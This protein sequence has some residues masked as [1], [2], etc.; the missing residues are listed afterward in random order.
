MKHLFK[1]SDVRDYIH[2]LMGNNLVVEFPFEIEVV[3]SSSGGTNKVNVK[4]AKKN[5]LNSRPRLYETMTSR[6]IELSYCEVDK[7]VKEFTRII[8][9]KEEE[10][11]KSRR[12]ELLSKLSP[13]VGRDLIKELKEE[14]YAAEITESKEMQCVVELT[15]ATIE[16]ISEV[17]LEHL[18]AIKSAATNAA[19]LIE[20]AKRFHNKQAKDL[21]SVEERKD[22]YHY[23]LRQFGWK[24]DIKKSRALS[25]MRDLYA[26][27]LEKKVEIPVSEGTANYESIPFIHELL[28]AEGT[29][30][31]Y[32]VGN[33]SGVFEEMYGL[34]NQGW[35]VTGT[36][37][38]KDDRWCREYE[39]H[40]IV[41]EFE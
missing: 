4:F 15:E 10:E 13:F 22:F 26:N 16:S 20:L 36:T 34:L 5:S 31:I 8:K 33:C 27:A 25:Y 39:Y 12:E 40:T 37:T 2:E 41:M 32:L 19:Y 30:K 23:R 7:L 29:S 11:V 18:E 1:V 38:I 14:G 28:L 24:T 17:T 35:K 9:F 3:Y 21:N 6:P